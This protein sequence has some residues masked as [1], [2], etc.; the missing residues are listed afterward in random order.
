VRTGI[1]CLLRN[2][3]IGSVH[4]TTLRLWCIDPLHSPPP[5]DWYTNKFRSLHLHSKRMLRKLKIY[6]RT[7]HASFVIR[8][9]KCKRVSSGCLSVIDLRQDQINVIKLDFPCQSCTSLDIVLG[10]GV[11]SENNNT[12]ANRLTVTIGYDSNIYMLCYCLRRKRLCD[13]C[14]RVIEYC[15]LSAN[16][17]RVV[18]GG[19]GSGKGQSGRNALFARRWLR[20]I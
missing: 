2:K 17:L 5:P 9:L 14:G 7:T 12:I 10:F 4:F 15:L 20:I 13:Q 11:I 19:R 1:I 3:C 6:R 16:T 8:I 18:S